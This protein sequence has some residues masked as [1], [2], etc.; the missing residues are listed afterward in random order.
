M[1]KKVLNGLLLASAVG[2]MLNS[3]ISVS[4]ENA[5][6]HIEAEATIVNMTVPGTVG[7]IFNENGT[8]TLPDN[9]T[10]R[11]NSAIGGI[12]VSGISVNANGSGWQ[13]VNSSTDLTKVGVDTKSI[14]LK[15]GEE[16]SLKIVNPTNGSK[17]STGNAEFGVNEFVIPAES[18]K[19]IKFGVERGAFSS[20]VTNAKAFDMGISFDWVTRSA[21]LTTGSD[22]QSKI[23]SL[24]TTPTTRMRLVLVNSIDESKRAGSVDVSAEGNGSVIAYTE[25]YTDSAGSQNVICLAFEGVLELNADSSHVFENFELVSDDNGSSDLRL[26]DFSKVENASYMFSYSTNPYSISSIALPKATNVS[27]MFDNSTFVQGVFDISLP[28]A[29]TA[30]G[31]FKEARGL[32]VVSD[33]N[34]PSVTTANNMFESSVIKVISDVKFSDKLK[35]ADYMFLDAHLGDSNSSDNRL[36]MSDWGMSGVTQAKYMFSKFAPNGSSPFTIKMFDTSGLTD[37]SY[38]FGG[39]ALAEG[40]LG[41][42]NIDLSYN[43]FDNLEK[44]DYMFNGCMAFNT[45][46]FIFENVSFPKLTSAISMFDN[47]PIRSGRVR[48]LSF[49]VLGKANRM[50]GGNMSYSAVDLSSFSFGSLVS[51]NNMINGFME[52]TSMD[53]S[54]WGDMSKL[55]YANNMFTY[56]YG[57]KGSLGISS[58]NL[59][60]LKEANNFIN[61]APQ[62]NDSITIRNAN[63]VITL[64]DVCESPDS[65]LVINYVDDA[66]RLIAEKLVAGTANDRVVLGT[67]VQ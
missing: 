23:E 44:A 60:S 59:S 63:T 7:M 4:A 61:T 49:P 25:S 16:N 30:E 57:V 12:Y 65:G 62:I 9:F 52:A 54:S 14:K 34:L 31:M 27:Y 29:T 35:T 1:R 66:T 56:L 40:M 45:G 32:G 43:N 67:K 8:N 17:D 22:F 18:E 55:E 21:K 6:I 46:K 33:I 39:N 13:L 19:T 24:R 50:F 48:N 36:D 58:W 42:I 64:S 51:A 2:G 20:A 3:G 5:D 41:D 53:L 37:G 26:V 38:L 15:M 10:I 28:S 11:N 47:A